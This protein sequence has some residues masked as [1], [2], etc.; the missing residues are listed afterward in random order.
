[1]HRSLVIAAIL[2]VVLATAGL[3]GFETA[4]AD[5]LSIS[6]TVWFDVNSDGQRQANESGNGTGVVLYGPGGTRS[7]TKA[8]AQGNY[9]FS[10][11]T[12]GEYVVEV[13]L[14]SFNQ[15][16]LVQGEEKSGPPFNQTVTLTDAPVQHVDFVFVNAR[17]PMFTGLAFINAAPADF[18]KVRAFIDGADCTG[19]PGILPTDLDAATYQ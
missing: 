19:P 1:M 16:V 11:L 10:G 5:D 18:P 14:T 3:S 6:G 12:A 8:D 4:S 7:N 15:M 2:S 9:T 17:L 13:P